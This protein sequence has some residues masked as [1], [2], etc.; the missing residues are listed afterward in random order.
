MAGRARG[1]E[2][3]RVDDVR[4]RRAN[5]Q[6]VVA[7]GGVQHSRECDQPCNRRWRFGE[8]PFAKGTVQG[9]GDIGTPG[10]Q[11]PCPGKGDKPHRY[12]FTLFALNTDRLD[13]PPNATAAYVGFNIHS[14]QLAKA[15][16]TAMYGR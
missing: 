14:H 1:H 2:E 3:L 6:R 4:S 10:Y 7:L 16:L 15:T 9:N 5:G 13:L 8:E 11:G 12:V